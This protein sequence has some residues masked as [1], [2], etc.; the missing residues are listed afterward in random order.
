MH[1]AIHSC[2][3]A[4]PAPLQ[5]VAQLEAETQEIHLENQQLNKQ[6]TTLNAEASLPRI[7]CHEGRSRTAAVQALVSS[8]AWS[9]AASGTGHLAVCVFQTAAAAHRGVN[10]PALAVASVCSHRCDG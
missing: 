3:D 5:E 9:T 1:Q 7:W 8:W 6:Q 4:L 10:L 2:S